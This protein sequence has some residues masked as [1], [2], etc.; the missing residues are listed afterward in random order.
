MSKD[1]ILF[2]DLDNCCTH[3]ENI[4]MNISYKLAELTFQMI[5][6]I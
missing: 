5:I 3:E 4:H 6:L 1:H 2:E